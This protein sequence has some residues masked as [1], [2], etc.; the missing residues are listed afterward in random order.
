[1]TIYVGDIETDGFL[2]VMTKTHCIVLYDWETEQYLRFNDQP[3]ENRRHP[4]QPIAEAIRLLN[5]AD[6]QYFHYGHGFDFPALKRSYSEFS[7]K[8]GAMMDTV[9][10]AT[11]VYRNIKGMD[12]AAMMKGKRP[13]G[14]A[15][16]QLV[17]KH[18]LKAWGERLGVLKG[19]IADDSGI[20]DWTLW[21]PEL[22]DYCV[23]DVTVTVALLKLLL[24]GRNLEL[25]PFHCHELDNGF[26]HLMARQERQ[27]FVFNEAAAID[28]YG[29]LQQNL[30]QLEGE[31]KTIFPP[32]FAKGKRF[33]PKRDNKKSGYTA[34][35]PLTKVEL[36]EFN[37]GSR[38]HIQARLQAVY[39][40]EPVEFGANGKATADEST[41]SGLPYPAVPKLMDYLV[42]AKTAGALGNGNKAW[43]KLVKD[44]GRVHG[45]INA[46][47]AVTWRCTH[48]NPNMGQV[49]S[50]AVDKDGHPVWGLAG[51]YG[52][53][54]RS[55]F[56]VPEGSM[57]CGHDGSGLELRC[58]AHYMARYDGGAYALLVVDGDVH[59]ANQIA[60]GLR[61]RK[62]AK[63]YI[64]GFL[65]G[66]GDALLGGIVL[67]DMN[68]ED[69]AKFYAKHGSS[70]KK[71]Q[72]ALTALGT[73]SR[74]NIS[75][76]LPALGQLIEA[77]KRQ[78]KQRGFLRGLD[79]RMLEVRSQHSALNTLLQ[80]AGALIMKRWLVLVD[81]HLQEA[82]LVP[83]EWKHYSQA[84]DY[85]YVA[86]VHDEAQTEVLESAVETYDRI[87]LAAFPLA[88]E[89]YNFRC[90]IGG[91]GKSGKTW[92]ETH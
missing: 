66:A 36:T 20:T 6:K 1:M 58:L 35:A 74:K 50:V 7:P 80:S 22:E 14:F 82:G 39:G 2:E 32:F 86:N 54:C 77:V 17:G 45:R 15:N 79:G 61:Q 18:S 88:G 4:A 72:T 70:G 64:Y 53:D 46:M 71:F 42:T 48:S 5:L 73:K 62:N 26:Q 29:G 21:T 55:L 47:G 49:S 67:E 16:R 40:W 44:D 12:F 24:S 60:I 31:L 28:L 65:Y 52:A 59:T 8:P 25:H 38:D 91:A 30:V 83:H 75:E 3:A 63:T 10:M 85:E 78:A 81:Q 37:P 9:T 27:G 43:L 76:G 68:D 84:S 89:F 11:A 87:A 19:S 13:E 51:K 41:L 33:V 56:T 90:P 23:Q 69:K 92:T 57:L 34:N